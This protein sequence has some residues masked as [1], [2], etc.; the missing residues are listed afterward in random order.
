VITMAELTGE[1]AMG[2]PAVV[3]AAVETVPSKIC[4]K[5]GLPKPLG[6]FSRNGPRRR[7]DCKECGK[8]RNRAYYEANP[9]VVKV[10]TG[11]WQKANRAQANE[12]ARRWREAHPEEAQETDRRGR[13]NLKAK[14]FEHYGTKCACCGAPDR[15][16]IDHVSGGG[17]EHRKTIRRRGGANFYPRVS[18][19]LAALLG[20]R[21]PGGEGYVHGVGSRPAAGLRM[22]V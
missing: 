21:G 11:A 10:R 4:T 2:E 14:V 18:E 19:F 7:P 22:I 5:C 1:R 13:T 8:G 15:L 17:G 6:E 9:E 3:T 16:S 20:R 12:Y